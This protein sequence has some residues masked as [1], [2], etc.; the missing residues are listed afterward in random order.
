MK[1][2]ILLFFITILLF[3]NNVFAENLQDFIADPSQSDEYV[4]DELSILSDE[5]KEY[6]NNTNRDLQKKTGGQVVI[7]IVDSLEGFTLEE[8]TEEIFQKWGIGDSKK[9]NGILMFFAM[10]DRK[11][12]IETGYGTEGF[13]PDAYASR[14]IRNMAAF[15]IDENYPDGILEGYN[16]VLH[17]YSQEYKINIENSDEPYMDY[18]E[19]SEFDEDWIM[20]FIIVIILIVVLSSFNNPNNKNNKGNRRRRG[21][22]FYPNPPYGGSGGGFFGGG[23]SGGGFGGGFSGGG[24]RSGGGG[25]SG[26]W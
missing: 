23:F 9:S 10:D 16:E 6:I 21:G 1:K 5:D 4:Y 14:I 11:M 20:V 12:R 26:G 3:G 24:G 7:Y 15:F 2:T 18:T 17:F 25:A 22:G 8:V 19:E 13:I